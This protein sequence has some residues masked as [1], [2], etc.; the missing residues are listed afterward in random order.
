VGVRRLVRAC[1]RGNVY[2][3]SG[4]ACNHGNHGNHGP[5]GFPSLLPGQ[6]QDRHRCVLA[7]ITAVQATSSERVRRERERER[8]KASCSVL[9]LTLASI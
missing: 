5:V 2:M 3:L 1:E 6:P 8:N 9:P 4:I 7:N